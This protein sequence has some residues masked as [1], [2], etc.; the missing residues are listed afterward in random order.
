VKRFAS[1]GETDAI[2]ASIAN[3]G[4]TNSVPTAMTPGQLI[5]IIAVIFGRGIEN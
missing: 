3:T 5:V 2:I 4:W 1:T